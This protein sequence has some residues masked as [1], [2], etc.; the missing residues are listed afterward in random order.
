[1]K[2]ET[3]FKTQQD[4]KV[5]ADTEA[6]QRDLDN[7]RNDFRKTFCETPHGRRV[8]TWL[9]HETYIYRRFEQQNAK[10]YALEGKRELGL[11]VQDLI[12]LTNML[13]ALNNVTVEVKG[14]KR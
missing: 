8:L 14:N 1:M 9:V 11:E 4:A 2:K 13:Q 10:A 5:K 6:I 7:W 3:L 12:G